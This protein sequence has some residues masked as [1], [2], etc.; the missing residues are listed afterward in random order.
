MLSPDVCRPFSKDRR[1][2]VLGEGGAI[3]VLEDWDR[4][5][6]RGAT[7]HAEILGFGRTA[8]V[9]DLLATDRPGA[10]RAMQGALDD[11]GLAAN[12]VDYIN[13]HGTGTKLND[14]AESA[15]LGDLLGERLA[16]VPVTSTKSMV[17][18]CLDAA[19]AIEAV[20]TIIALRDGV[21]PPTIGFTT[22]DPD[23]PVD[24]VPKEHA[25]CR[26]RS[27]CRTLSPTAD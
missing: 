16:R 9:G 26:S 8:D 20:A 22:P 10:L 4:A 7:I 25:A 19:G 21:I 6:A 12:Q 17:G 27:R 5:R 18:H 24:C 1:G 23:C 14:L 11:A 15:V 3:L 13:A 2:L